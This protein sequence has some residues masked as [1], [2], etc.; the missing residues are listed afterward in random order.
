MRSALLPFICVPTSVLGNLINVTV[1]DTK[2]DPLTGA[3]S[4]Y[5]PE[6]SWSQGNGCTVCAAKPD[7]S[8]ALDAIWHDITYTV[9]ASSQTQTATLQFNGTF[10]ISFLVDI[11]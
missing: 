3:S 6:G 4:V 2:P 8:Q 1:D 7:A 11:S 9:P 10:A 5:V